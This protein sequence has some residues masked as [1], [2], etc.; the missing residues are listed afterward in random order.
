MT[1]R[2]ALPLIALSLAALATGCD[3]RD[4]GPYTP[5]TVDR[6]VL[7]HF[8]SCDDVVDYAQYRALEQVGPYGLE[9][10][11]GWGWDEGFADGGDG[12]GDV[13]AD[14]G[15]EDGGDNGGGSPEFSGTNVQELGVDEP[16]IVKTDGTRILAL[17]QGSLHYV[18]VAGE[19][20]VRMGS[21]SV[22][23]TD[24]EYYG[25]QGAQML[26][27]GDRVLLAVTRGAW[28]LPAELRDAFGLSEED[29]A[30]LVQLVEVDVSDP[31]AMQVVSNLYVEGAYVSGR[32]HD[33]TARV[34]LS[35]QLNRLPFKFPWDFLDEGDVELEGWSGWTDLAYAKAEAE[36]ES[37][38]R[39]LVL[40]TDLQDW[41]PRYVMQDGEGIHAGQLVECQRMMR[42]GTHAG[43]GTLSVLTIDMAKPLAL[44][45]AV[46]LFSEGQTV[47]ASPDRLYVATRPMMQETEAEFGEDEQ[48]QFSSFVHQFDISSADA[49]HYQASGEVP[50]YLLNQWAMSE[51]DGALRVAT[52]EWG[53][54]DLSE[55]Y[56]TVLRRNGQHL[57]TVGQVGGLGKGEQ[58]YAVRFMGDK[59]YVVTFRQ[60]DP[61]YTLDLSAPEAPAVVGELK[62]NGY[63]AYLHPVGDDLLLGVGR[64]GTDEGQVL[65]TQVSL[66]DVSDPAAPVA[67]FQE[68]FGEWASSEVEFD[69]HAFL[70]WEAENLAVFPVQTWGWNEDTG[71]EESFGGALA[72]RIDP[73]AGIQL[74]G[75]IE[76]EEAA[77]LDT[78]YGPQIRRSLVIDDQ[79]YTLSEQ[80]VQRNALADLLP[81]GWVGF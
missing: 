1:T 22:L 61:L 65:G 10:D 17:A 47:Y 7:V 50:G 64:D 62:I 57:D 18:D 21:L 45:D 38:N 60:I 9:G 33:G 46:G 75:T 37:Y 15:G 11:Y 32:L 52:T 29:Y 58:I 20:P 68:S 3:R 34:V 73:V 41:V 69:H 36:A 6:A 40:D 49:A 25:Y 56:V 63:S 4:D 77:N 80:G 16:D 27:H 67:L 44:G 35:S 72:Y 53:F 12:G 24:G 2:T 51:Y 31:A 39:A 5:E 28:D 54:S 66:F 78:W 74:V 79:L 71:E 19:A 48:P 43:L 81:S 70:Y 42:P 76:H 59:G 13:P 55:S 14:G 23:Q 30:P 8:A 26:V